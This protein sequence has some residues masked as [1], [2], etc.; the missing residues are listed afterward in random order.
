MLTVCFYVISLLFLALVY[1]FGNIPDV[2]DAL[3]LFFNRSSGRVLN[4][5]S[6]WICR[7]VCPDRSD[8]KKCFEIGEYFVCSIN[9]YV[10]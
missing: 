4:V 1:R 9:V 5:I 8:E 2:P 6:D 10:I 7:N 3:V